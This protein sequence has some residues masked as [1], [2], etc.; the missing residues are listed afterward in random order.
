MIPTYNYCVGPLTLM[1][2]PLEEAM[3]L[4]PRNSPISGHLKLIQNNNR[5]L[6][7][8]INNLLQV[9]NRNIYVIFFDAWSFNICICR[10]SVRPHR[11]KPTSRMVLR[12]EH[13]KVNNRIGSQFRKYG[14]SA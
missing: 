10:K 13:C 2:S 8:L 7:N 6:L 11:G 1:L 12:I 14:E 4:C 9:R 3:E 5:R